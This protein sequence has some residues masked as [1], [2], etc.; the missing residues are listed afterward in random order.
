MI[1]A[2]AVD[3]DGTFLNSQKDYNRERFGRLY[4]EMKRRGIR[5]IVAS[6]NQYVQI[7]RSFPD[8]CDEI[9][10]VAENGSCVMEGSRLLFKQTV[11]REDVL[12]TAS[13]L[14]EYKDINY[15]ACGLNATYYL[16]RSSDYFTEIMDFYCP[17]N[18][19]LDSLEDMPEDDIFK[20][21][22]EC[23]PEKTGEYAGMLNERL[24]GRLE[25]TS[26]GHGSIDLII[27]GCH[28]AY[29]LSKLLDYYGIDEADLMAC[30]DGGNDI[31]M[32]QMAG[33]SYAMS[34][35]SKEA[36]KTAGNVTLSNDEDGV[37]VALER[38][39]AA[40]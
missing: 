35:G 1:K 10:Y 32:L 19:K 38:E 37:L 36:R 14:D 33:H 31:E 2:L 23:P 17:V 21:T 30:G 18:E 3:M 4:E 12:F 24:A 22:I 7:K 5:F 6:G 20:L 13:V 27:P 26:S 25:A 15:A 29:G 8:I 40:D 16:N 11:S 34:N 39:L 28:K 9:S